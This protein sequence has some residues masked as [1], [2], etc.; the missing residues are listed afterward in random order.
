LLFA[1]DPGSEML[2]VLRL[3]DPGVTATRNRFVFANGVLLYGPIAVTPD[4]AQKAGLAEGTAI[5]YR[6][7]VAL[8]SKRHRRPATAKWTDAYGLLHGLAARLHGEIDDS[9]PAIETKLGVDVYSETQLAVDDLTKLL[10]PFLG[11]RPTPIQDDDMPTD[12]Y[13]L[14]TEQS[15]LFLVSYYPPRLARAPS[16]RAPAAIGDLRD[17]EPH[18]WS[19]TTTFTLP[20]VDR[21]TCL[22]LGQAAIDL[23]GAVRGVAVDMWGFPI[24]RPA[25]LFSVAA[26]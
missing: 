14:V 24:D 15:P 25:E 16:N 22:T 3:Y 12:S 20:A 2:H 26:P 13:I 7:A 1:S 11:E 19:F 5:A 4:I 21:D 9:R 18:H 8:Q 6:A 23:S 10:E 17:R